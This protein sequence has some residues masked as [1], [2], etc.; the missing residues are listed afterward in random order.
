MYNKITMRTYLKKPTRAELWPVSQR[1]NLIEDV[2]RTI[3]DFHE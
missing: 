1:N 2:A 3:I